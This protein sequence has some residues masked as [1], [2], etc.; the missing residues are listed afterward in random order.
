MTLF[1]NDDLVL[2]GVTP[3]VIGCFHVT[4]HVSDGGQVAEDLS[5][6]KMFCVVHGCSNRSNR[7]KKSFLFIRLRMV[8][9]HKGEKGKKL[10]EQRCKKWISTQ[11]FIF[12]PVVFMSPFQPMGPY[13]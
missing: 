8:V 1:E 13:I 4:S 5:C 3:I 6:R 12:N 2:L 7:K 10:T 11:L 9:V